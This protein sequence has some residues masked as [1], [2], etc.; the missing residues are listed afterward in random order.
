[1]TIDELRI[2]ADKLGYSLVK[3]KLYMPIAPCPICGAIRG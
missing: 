1:M 2:E 3:K